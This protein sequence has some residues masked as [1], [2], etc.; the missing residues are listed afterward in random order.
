MTDSIS[1]HQPLRRQTERAGRLEHGDNS[2]QNLG[3]ESRQQKSL[4]ASQVCFGKMHEASRRMPAPIQIDPPHCLSST[5][6]GYSSTRNRLRLHHPATL[7]RHR[8]ASASVEWPRSNILYSPVDIGRKADLDYRRIRDRTGPCVDDMA[9]T[10]KSSR[11][12]N[13][14]ETHEKSNL[15]EAGC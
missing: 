8:S 6:S 2:G 3:I 5:S 1:R 7:P 9:S 10:P 14:M 13:M 4:S 11:Q 15:V 12:S